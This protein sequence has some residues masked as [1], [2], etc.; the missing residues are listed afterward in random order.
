MDEVQWREKVRADL[1][2]AAANLDLN[3][4]GLAR[5][6]GFT[7]SGLHAFR[8]NCYGGYEKVKRL[9]ARLATYGFGDV[10]QAPGVQEKETDATSINVALAAQFQAVADTLRSALPQEEKTKVYLAFVA[11]HSEAVNVY[12]TELEKL[13][14]NRKSGHD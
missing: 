11:N 7:P 9:E 6:C 3:M 4:A 8:T 1:E 14:N 2:K 5:E 12:R 10:A 13:E